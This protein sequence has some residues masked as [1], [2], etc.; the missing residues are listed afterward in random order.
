L[1]IARQYLGPLEEPA[2]IVPEATGGDKNKGHAM[3]VQQQLI[4]YVRPSEVDEVERIAQLNGATV[5]KMEV[6]GILPVVLIPLIILGTIAVVATVEHEIEVHRGGQVI[7][8]SGS[9]P[10]LYRDHDL[11]YGLIVVVKKD[12]TVKISVSDVK[13]LIGQVLEAITKIL[14]DLGKETI[15]KAAEAIKTAVGDK[16]GVEVAPRRDTAKP[17]A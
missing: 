9:V 5:E 6:S 4:V 3:A 13:E 17:G 15:D 11:Q 14:D 8:L 1:R 2:R 7:D 12:G 10:K 16:A